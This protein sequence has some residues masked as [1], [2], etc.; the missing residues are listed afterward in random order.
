MN[1]KM[2]NNL[3]GL[4]L[5]MLV[6]A[7][8][9]ANSGNGD[10]IQ[11][12]KD[13][14]EQDRKTAQQ[15]DRGHKP[16]PMTAERLK[17]VLEEYNAGQDAELSWSEYNDW[18]KARFDSTDANH[19]GTV[20]TEEYVYE[21]EGRMDARIDEERLAQVKQTKMRFEALDADDSGAIAWA[22][23]AASGEKIFKRW[24]SNQD[25]VIDAQ[26]FAAN[27]DKEN[28]QRQQRRSMIRMPTTHN[29][30]GVLEL[31]DANGDEFVSHEE[32]I[33]ERKSL[34]HLADENKNGQVVLDEYLAEY[35]NRLDA[36]IAKTRRA[37]IK[38]TYVRFGV[39]DDNED[40]AMTFD[41]FQISGKRIF[42]RWD[43]NSDGII[44]IA[45]IGV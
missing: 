34:F 28:N 36:A 2:L 23:L 20:D 18:R 41:E 35:E 13:L 6:I 5:A 21:Y 12:A 27:E 37:A 33:Q 39:L 26:D 4:S 45:D 30:A 32:F 1:H 17:Q 29:R 40:K 3:T 25:G 11:A 9:A 19:N 42:T 16:Q 38:Q 43:K 15:D 7:G 8:C 14:T 31:Y 10:A 22:E 44:S 24:D